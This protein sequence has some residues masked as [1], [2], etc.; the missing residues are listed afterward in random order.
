MLRTLQRAAWAAK[1]P[2]AMA[3]TTMAW[4]PAGMTVHATT[5]FA[6]LCVSAGLS[7][8]MAAAFQRTKPHVNIGTIG[9]VD[10][11]KTT[12]TAAIT[13]VLSEM[14]DEQVSAK[15]TDYDQID[16][17]PEEKARG[18][19]INT[20]HVEYETEARHYAHVDCPGHADYVKN[21]IT[22]AA[23][24]DGGIL[25]V[26]A[27]DGAM[28]QTT[29]HL[30]L[31]SQVGVKNLVVYINKADMEPEVELVEFEMRELLEQYG[32]DPESPIVSGSALCALEGREDDTLGRDSIVKLMSAVDSFIETP[33]RDL[34]KPFL[35]PVEDVFSIAGRGTVVTGR[36]ERGVIHKGRDIEVIGLG[37]TTK[38]VCT[39]VEM[40][41][42]QLEAGEAGD[43]VGILLRGVKRDEVKR[44]QVLAQPGSVTQHNKFKASLYVRKK[45]EGGRHKPFVSHYRPQLFFRTADVTADLILQGVDVALLGNHVD[46][47]VTLQV[48]V[49]L[50]K[51]MRFTA[52][53]GRL[54]IGTGVVTEVL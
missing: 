19:T 20:A 54:T 18:I 26:S 44:G 47:D 31:A 33:A 50:E 34:E 14:K 52:R 51:G 38:S 46:V 41:R 15:F 4:A 32:F 1:G 10:H 17:A 2:V 48:P 16:K 11:G 30:L 24:M 25:V 9:H 42:K 53:E 39:G 43:N 23:Q 49:P 7:K 5:V 27:T 35:M 13:K 12:L 36:V 29:E 40:F 22:G 3:A 45:E 8:I 37:K 6:P 21:M 28:P